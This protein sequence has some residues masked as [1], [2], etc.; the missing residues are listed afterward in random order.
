MYEHY[1]VTRDMVITIDGL[2]HPAGTLVR[3]DAVRPGELDALIADGTLIPNGTDT[4]KTPPKEPHPEQVDT[5]T[6][7]I[8]P[9]VKKGG[10]K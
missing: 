10:R 1:E 7:V 6:K 2:G 4:G 3:A 9:T 5:L 8:E